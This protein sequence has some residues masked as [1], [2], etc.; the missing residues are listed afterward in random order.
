MCSSELQPL[1]QVE[2][3]LRGPRL[4]LFISVELLSYVA[5]CT[6]SPALG[7]AGTK[8]C[9]YIHVPIPQYQVVLGRLNDSPAPEVVHFNSISCLVVR[10]QTV[11]IKSKKIDDN[12]VSK[13]SA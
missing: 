8:L 2:Q 1:A 3:Q 12:P 11:L 9:S 10:Q 5:T 13:E 7:G 4:Q 6:Y